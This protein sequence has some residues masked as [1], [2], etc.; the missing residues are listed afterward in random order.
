MLLLHTAITGAQTVAEQIRAAVERLRIRKVALG[1]AVAQDGEGFD[2]LMRRAD[3]ALDRAK[4]EGR[5]RVSV[6][7]PILSL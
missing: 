2:N 4:H 6:A 3:A 1:V 7:G 5:N